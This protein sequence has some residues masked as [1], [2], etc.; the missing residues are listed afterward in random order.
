VDWAVLLV[1][2]GRE[3]KAGSMGDAVTDTQ[4]IRDAT[5]ASPSMLPIVARGQSMDGA[6]AKFAGVPF[7][8]LGGLKNSCGDDFAVHLR[9]TDIQKHLTGQ[10]VC[11]VN[12]V[13]FLWVKRQILEEL[14]GIGHDFP[15]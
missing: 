14:I 11:L 12:S 10:V 1:L 15:D 13:N 9:L 8:A 3:G 2:T 6:L 7:A 4:Q 5:P